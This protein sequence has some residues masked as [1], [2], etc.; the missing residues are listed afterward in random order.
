MA[1][2]DTMAGRPTKYDKAMDE[3]VFRLCLLGAKDTEIAAFFGVNETTLNRWKKAH[4]SFCLSIKAGKEDADAKVAESLYNR[5][6]GYSHH[7]DK[8]FYD[9]KTGEVTTVETTKHY[10]PDTAAAFIW[11]KNR[12]GY[13]WRDRKEHVVNDSAA[14]AQAMA[15]SRLVDFLEEHAPRGEA[16]NPA[17]MGK[18]GSVLPPPLPAK[19]H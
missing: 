17:D 13:E 8:I 16:G 3:Q 6:L 18:D 11:L 14:T 1:E 4:P 12:R 7:E 5:A 10:P 2:T 19:P 15:V 9:S